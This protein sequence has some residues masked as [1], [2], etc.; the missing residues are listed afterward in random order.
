MT[1]PRETTNDTEVEQ[2]YAGRPN[3]DER[4]P[5]EGSDVGGPAGAVQATVGDALDDPDALGDDD[6]ARN[7]I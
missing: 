4:D 3:P 6:Q 7:P 1:D 2:H 5:N